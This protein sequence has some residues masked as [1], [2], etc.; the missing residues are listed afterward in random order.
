MVDVVDHEPL[1]LALVPDDGAVKEFSAQGGDPAFGER[2]GHWDT[3]RGAQDLETFGSADLVE[4]AGELAGAV[5]PKCSS[6]GEPLWVTQA[7]VAR[8]LG[9]PGAGRVGGDAAVED[10]AGGDVDEEQQVVAA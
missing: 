2:V 7:Q 4:V 8:C 5:S 9:G 1:E 6:V 10:F 3:S